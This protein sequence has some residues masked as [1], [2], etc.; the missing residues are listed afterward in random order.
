MATGGT[1]DPAATT[2]SV[3]AGMRSLKMPTFSGG[4]E[5]DDLSPLD[6]V[7]RIETYVKSA[8]RN[9]NDSCVEM[10]LNLRGNALIWWR[11]LKRRGVNT[12][13][14]K[15]VRQAFLETYAPTITGQ[16]AHAIGQMEQRANETVND[17]FGRLDQIVD[18][19]LST[20]PTPA[21]SYVKT[22]EDVR[23]HMQKYLFIGGL[24][25]NIRVEVLKVTPTTLADALKEAC[26]AE[27][28]L[29]KQN[30]RIFAIEDENNEQAETDLDDDEI[31]AINRRRQRL[32]KRPI[33]RRRPG[34][35]ANPNAN[36]N[37]NDIKCYN[38]NRM[39]HISKNCTAPRRKPIKA[40]EENQEEEEKQPDNAINAIQ[41]RDDLDFW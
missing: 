4:L 36:A 17:Y 24:R 27:L 25:E 1:N 35:N 28:I 11:T 21:T 14:W 40:I 30:N 26:K 12:E 38:C 9:D 13:N 22:Y 29:K 7:E 5:K 6:F 18:E 3:V 16:T 37:A 23:N 34:N 10:H 41:E 32:G 8:K 39:G 19:M 31:M 33:V 20:F 2:P 15:E